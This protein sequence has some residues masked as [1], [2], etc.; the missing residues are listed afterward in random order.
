MSLPDFDPNNSEHGDAG[1]DLQ[2]RHARHLRDGLDLQDLHRGDG[3][4]RRTHDARRQLRRDA[5]RIHIGRFTIHDDHAQHRWLTVPEIF[6]YSSNIGAARMAVDAGTD[7]QQRVP[8]PARPAAR[9]RPSSCPRSARR[10]CRRP[11]GEVNTMT[12]AFGHGI[13]VSPLQIA[14]AVSAVVNGGML[15]RATLIKQSGG[16]RAGRPAGAVGADLGRDAPAAAPRRRAGH[17][18]ARRRRPAISSAAR[19]APPRRSPARAT[20]H[21]QL[22]SSFVGVFPIND[23]RYLVMI[24]I[25]EPHGNKQS[26]GFATGGW[27]AAPGVSRVVAAHGAAPRNSTGRRRIA[28]NPPFFDGRFT[29]PSGSENCG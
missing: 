13:S 28:R 10:W 1:D 3:A 23:P 20:T 12:V 18:Q 4:R 14:T 29:D 16:L 2:P 19:P 15:H 25:D 11:G 17:R 8:R 26:A 22:L 9:R 5:I 24:S 21:K 7:R 6:E 27:A